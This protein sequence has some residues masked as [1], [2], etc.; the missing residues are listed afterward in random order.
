VP[1]ASRRPQSAS[2]EIVLLM[3]IQGAG[4]SSLVDAWVAKGYVRLNRDLE[5]GRVRDLHAKLG[6][7]LA[8]GTERAVLDNTY[9]SRAQRNEAIE[10]AWRHGA[11]A[12]CVWV[13]TP[14][15]QAQINV[16]ARMLE[17][18]GQLLGPEEIKRISRTDPGVF[19]PDVQFRFLRQLEPPVLDEGFESIERAELVR[20]YP[21]ENRQRALIV[22]LDG[23]LRRS[24]SG[25]RTPRDVDDLELDAA[26]LDVLRRY[27]REGWLLA[28]IAWLPE[29]AAKKMT[30]ETAA[31][32]FHAMQTALGEEM[33]FAYCPHGAGPAVCWCRRPLPGLGVSLIRS[34][35]LDPKRCIMVGRGGV[36]R[37]FAERLGF[38]YVDHQEFF[39]S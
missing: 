4:K 1:R 38:P 9:A 25:A 28:G 18:H 23:V 24:R 27:V 10:I 31:A 37:T 2:K 8:G 13:D 22:E 35:A 33:A 15:E 16:V 3:G 7:L 32:I 20:R 14:I 5:G 12:R 29:V 26:R 21:S 30:E 34:L 11:Y 17:R 39:R 19:T 36:D 6:H